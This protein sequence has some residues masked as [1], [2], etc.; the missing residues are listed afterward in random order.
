MGITS[1]TPKVIISGHVRKF[2]MLSVIFLSI[3]LIDFAQNCTDKL[4]VFQWILIVLLLLQIWFCFV[5]IID[6][7]YCLFLTLINLILLKCLTLPQD[8]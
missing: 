4:Q 2:V 7:S 5:N 1:E 6:T 8:I 3:Y